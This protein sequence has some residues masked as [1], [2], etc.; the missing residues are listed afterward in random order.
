MSTST[1][2]QS[3]EE[4]LRYPT[5]KFH[6]PRGPLT[7]SQ[8]REMIDVIARTPSDLR[9]AVRGLSDAQLDTPYRPGGWTVRQVVHHVPDSHMNA[10]I[11]FKLALTEET[12]TIKPYDE[13]AW[14]KLSDVGQTP[15]ETSL[16]LLS[17]LHDRWVNLMRGMSSSDFSRTLKHPE[18]DDP[19]SLDTVLALYAWHG[20]HHIAHITSLKQRQG[21]S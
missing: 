5:G 11:R 17:A 9:A 3:T 8:R 21:W 12:P 2:P 18:W 16:T 15:I 6:R 10:F 4:T 20:P 13:A 19:M 1:V 14:A 7:D